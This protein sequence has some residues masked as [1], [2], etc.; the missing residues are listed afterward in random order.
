MEAIVHMLDNS[1]LEDVEEI[2]LFIDWFDISCSLP[3]SICIVNKYHN[4]LLWDLIIKENNNI[5]VETIDFIINNHFPKIVK[6]IPKYKRFTDRLKHIVTE[7]FILKYIDYID[8]KRISNRNLSENFIREHKDK[9]NWSSV[10]YELNLS[11]SFIREFQ[12]KLNWRSVSSA[13]RLSE[14]FIR[15]FKDKVDWEKISEAQK[16]SE[17]FIREFKDKVDWDN[18]SLRQK[19][20]ES[21]AEEFIEDI[22]LSFLCCNI[23]SDISEDFI[24][25]HID[26]LHWD[27]IGQA[28]V[29]SEKFIEDYEEHL[30]W[31]DLCEC[32]PLSEEFILKHIDKICWESLYN[33]DRLTVSLQFIHDHKDNI[34]EHKSRFFIEHIKKQRTTITLKST[35]IFSDEIVSK[36]ISFLYYDYEDDEEDGDD[37]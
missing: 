35:N 4:H 10:S 6:Y 20:S 11:E 27:D 15:E 5:S 12:N 3:L 29:W 14:S 24:R 8:W 28:R 7:E 32:Q 26:R 1:S 30:C 37:D 18:I 9:V 34:P 16:L 33:S 19:I 17:S 21:F 31:E 2:S 13:S 25:R 36:I 23:D 22:I